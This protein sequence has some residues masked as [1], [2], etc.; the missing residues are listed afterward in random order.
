MHDI[1][2][3]ILQWVRHHQAWAGLVTFLVAFTESLAIVG[4]FIPGSVM[5]IAIGSLVGV[6]V[7]SGIETF[8]AAILGAVSGDAISY[9][10][11]YHYHVAIRKIWPFS[12]FTGLLD[13]GEKFF[14]KHGGKSVFLGRFLGPLR[15]TMPII[16][17]MLNLQPTRFFIANIGSALLWAPGYLLPGVLVGAGALHIS[18]HKAGHLFF[19][20]LVSLII[21]SI[22]YVVF[23][24]LLLKLYRL[25]DNKLEKGWKVMQAHGWKQWLTDP[26][27]P[28][29]HHQLNLLIWT[30]VLSG[31]FALLLIVVWFKLGI[32][33]I[34]YSSHVSF[35]ELRHLSLD[36]IFILISL[37]GEKIVL[38]P[39]LAIV[40]S[41]LII[42]KYWRTA[43]H[44][45]ALLIS[46]IIVAW[47]AKE[48]THSIRPMGLI[49][50][51][52]DFSFPSGHVTFASGFWG[53]TAYLFARQL[54]EYSK[55]WPYAI[56]TLFVLLVGTSRLYLGMH[57][58]TDILGGLLLGGAAVCFTILSYQ[59]RLVPQLPK[60]KFLLCIAVSFFVVAGLYSLLTFKQNLHDYQPIITAQSHFVVDIN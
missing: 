48:L 19:H 6:G 52:T 3:H 34:N 53:F 42:N 49:A 20:A 57:W 8:I 25:I 35:M 45:A 41:Y 29:S 59:R 40:C 22:L 23:R 31:L 7:L 32:Q 16:S 10:L 5:L 37:L 14:A 43:A 13:K 38:L 54:S 2:P 50:G 39:V 11:G 55:H 30:F 46:L 44:Y 9:Y 21:V 27:E 4:L 36:R 24:N 33:T 17:G 51:P 26:N 1:I 18:P 56:A 28:H 15:P 47:L 12:R 60:G 58:L